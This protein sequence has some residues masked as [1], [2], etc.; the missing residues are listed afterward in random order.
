MKDLAN[1]KYYNC[2]QKS[3]YANKYPEKKPKN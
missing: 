3:Y 1:I 2:K